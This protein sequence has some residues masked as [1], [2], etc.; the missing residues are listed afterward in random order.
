MLNAVP[1]EAVVR[2]PKYDTTFKI[3]M[4]E[5][6]AEKRAISFINAVLN[7]PN[8]DEVIAIKYLESSDMRTE[9]RSIHFDV[10]IECTCETKLGNRFIVEMQKARFKG[11]TNRWVYYAARELTNIGQTNYQNFLN[12]PPENRK[13][14]NKAYY[15]KL[16]PVKVI[17]ILNFDDDVLAQELKDSTNTIIHWNITESK[18]KEI[19][20]DLLSWTYVVLPRFQLPTDPNYPTKLDLRT[21]LDAWL[22]LLTRT[23]HE[24]VIVDQNLMD[25][26]ESVADG[27]FRLSHL[28]VDENNQLSNAIEAQRIVWGREEQVRGEGIEEGRESVIESYLRNIKTDSPDNEIADLFQIPVAVIQSLKRKISESKK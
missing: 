22:Y 2:D 16:H 5:A 6:G 23:D 19:A 17:A 28:S 1:F 21:N 26:D 11:H 18:S 3:L 25:L 12:L 13:E 10:K 24:K 8:D 20:S 14:M 15:Q 27:F 9:D 4:G 7:L